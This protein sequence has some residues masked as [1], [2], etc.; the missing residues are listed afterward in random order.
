MR[1]GRNVIDLASERERRREREATARVYVDWTAGEV[2]YGWEHVTAGNALALLKP[3]LLI[4]GELLNK[5]TG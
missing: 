4:A 5:Y 3:L 1:R 2:A